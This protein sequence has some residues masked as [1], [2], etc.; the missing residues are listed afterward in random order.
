MDAGPL[1]SSRSGRDQPW[2]ATR[3]TL[4][5]AALPRRT[6]GSAHLYVEFERNPTQ[7]R[8]FSD[9]NSG[10]TRRMT[11]LFPFSVPMLLTARRGEFQ[12]LRWE[13]RRDGL[14]FSASAPVP[15]LDS[16]RQEVFDAGCLLVIPGAFQY[17]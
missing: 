11:I 9:R 13:R 6:S 1:S 16:T 12:N 2:R 4:R 3:F 10:K 14:P 7:D 5:V 15:R 8:L 17:H